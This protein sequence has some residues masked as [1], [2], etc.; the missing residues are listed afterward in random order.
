MLFIQLPGDNELSTVVATEAAG[1]TSSHI[2]Y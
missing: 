2:A 1:H